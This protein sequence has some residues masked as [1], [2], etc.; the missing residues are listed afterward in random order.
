MQFVLSIKIVFNTESRLLGAKENAMR[1]DEGL[2]LLVWACI[3][4][5]WG[6][7]I[8]GNDDDDSEEAFTF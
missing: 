2:R 8:D 7:L 5:L 6:F 4:Q 1:T 3:F